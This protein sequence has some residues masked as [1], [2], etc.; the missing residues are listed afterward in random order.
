M[1]RRVSKKSTVAFLCACVWALIVL[2]LS[3]PARPAEK[4][5]AAS[6]S[7]NDMIMVKAADMGNNSTI[8][9]TENDIRVWGYFY[10]GVQLFSQEK[11][12]DVA[13]GYKT[14]N[15]YNGKIVE[16]TT[17]I[18]D[19]EDTD[20]YDTVTLTSDDQADSVGGVEEVGKYANGDDCPY[21]AIGR[22]SYLHT[23]DDCEHEFTYGAGQA[24]LEEKDRTSKPWESI[25]DATHWAVCICGFKLQVG[26]RP[27]PDGKCMDCDY[28][29]S[30]GDNYLNKYS[31][32][33][34]DTIPDTEDWNTDDENPSISFDITLDENKT[35][36]F[37]GF[38][39]IL[40]VQ[41][42]NGGLV[43]GD[44]DTIDYT[45]SA[46]D[47]FSEG[48][49]SISASDTSDGSQTIWKLEVDEDTG[50]PVDDGSF[51]RQIGGIITIT[52]TV[53]PAYP[54]SYTDTLTFSVELIDSSEGY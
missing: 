33:I 20:D 40:K 5:H 26:H 36:I 38:T 11:E 28:K 6:Y 22:G 44:G 23:F 3:L 37:E 53:A 12:K 29:G 7:P 27:G 32:T 9:P 46:T 21:Y 34:P 25:N 51:R 35:K 19:V 54:G 52:L 45:I 4:A 47:D 48:E 10:R 41:S 14:A 24:A 30:L 15:T 1:E 43:N 42:E 8:K 18:R 17:K 2:C 49:F 39:L 50:D 31:F 13:A 16:G